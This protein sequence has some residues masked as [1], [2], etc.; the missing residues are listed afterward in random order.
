MT[1]TFFGVDIV[2]GKS[3][4]YSGRGGFFIFFYGSM[5]IF[6]RSSENSGRICLRTHYKVIFLNSNILKHV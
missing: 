1:R 3:G 5:K 2:N 4:V 6:R